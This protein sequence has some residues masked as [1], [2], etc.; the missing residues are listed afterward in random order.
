M[1]P[2]RVFLGLT[3]FLLTIPAM[4]AAPFEVWHPRS[5]LPTAS[6][7]NGVAY[8]NGRFVA[9]GDNGSIVTSSNGLDWVLNPSGVSNQLNTIIFA[10]GRFVAGGSSGLILWSDDGLSWSTGSFPQPSD[11][12]T[13]G[14]GVGTNFPDGLFVSVSSTNAFPGSPRNATVITSSNGINWA[15]TPAFVAGSIFGP[16]RSIASGNDRLVASGTATPGTPSPVAIVS[17][18]GGFWSPALGGPSGPVAFGNGFFVLAASFHVASNSASLLA[19]T[20]TTGSSWV[21]PSQTFSGQ[22]F[23]SQAACIG[24]GRFVVVGDT[25]LTG[26]STDGTNWTVQ[27]V[28]TDAQLR[29]VAYGEGTYVAVGSAGFIISSTDAESWTQRNE[30]TSRNLLAIAPADDGFVAVGSQGVVTWSSNGVAWETFA[31]PTANSLLDAIKADGKYVAAGVNGTIVSGDTPGNLLPRASGTTNALQRIAYGNG[32]FI[33]VGDAGTILSSQNGVDWNV[34]DAGVAGNLYDVVF[35]NGLFV[36]VGIEA[37]VLTSSDGIF[38]DL[39]PTAATRALRDIAYGGG[40]FV[41]TAWE[42][43]FLDPNVYVTTSLDG[44]NWEPAPGVYPEVSAGTSYGNGYFAIFLRSFTLPQI[45]TS[46]DG[47][48]WK[49]Y[50]LITNVPPGADLAFNNGT[51]VSVGRFGRIS[52]SDPVVR[53]NVCYD[54]MAQLSWVGP[55]QN[56]YRIDAVEALGATNSWQALTTVTSPPFSWTDPESHTRSNR[57]YRAVVLP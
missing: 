32:L 28:P 4:V 50:P 8:G 29:S 37:N 12:D 42:P 55:M 15:I 38:W 5:P 48:S 26:T 33:I 51:F 21:Q 27:R 43:L 9:V 40:R 17:T 24:G 44:V 11:V 47:V 14:F 39:R 7:L 25:G 46:A 20:S 6:T 52:Q 19:L 13:I 3:C 16:Y 53:L 34:E 23:A 1:H 10:A 30:G 41:A 45:A 35:G 18:S 36:A 22:V 31:A 57:V 2:I 49:S 56:Q 54:G